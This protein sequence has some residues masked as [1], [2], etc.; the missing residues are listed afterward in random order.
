SPNTASKSER[1]SPTSPPP[2]NRSR[3][4]TPGPP[5]P[6][7]PMPPTNPGAGSMSP[8]SQPSQPIPPPLSPNMPMPMGGNMQAPPFVPSQ[9][10]GGFQ[11]SQFP[12]S[13]WGPPIAARQPP[14]D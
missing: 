6:G 12:Q 2:P 7:L 9:Q 11:Q 5:L 8:M 13:G 4:P 10:A 3:G 14:R 1:R